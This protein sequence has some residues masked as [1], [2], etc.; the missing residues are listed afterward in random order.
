MQQKF[1]CPTHISLKIELDA[2][3]MFKLYFFL[4]TS[5]PKIK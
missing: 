5:I 3:M 2:K 4:N 1:A